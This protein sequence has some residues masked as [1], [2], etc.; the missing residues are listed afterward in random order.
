MNNS[1]GNKKNNKTLIALSIFIGVFVLFVFI[2]TKPSLEAKAIRQIEDCLNVPEVQAVFSIYKADLFKSEEFLQATRDKLNK[3]QLKQNDI[4]DIKKWLPAK[5]NNLNIIIVPDLSN[6]IIDDINNPDQ[7]KRDSVIISSIC[8]SFEEKVKLKMNSKDRLVVDVTDR[9]QAGG[10][11]GNLADSIMFDLSTFNNKSNRLYFDNK[12]ASFKVGISKLYDM[13]YNFEVKNPAGG[14]ADYVSYFASKLS[15]KL[16]KSTLDDD[17]QNIL[18][19]LTDG[20]LEATKPDGSII[21]YLKQ[22]PA[23]IT[24][25]SFT[26]YSDLE[27]YLLDVN[28]RK[29][30]S[31]LEEFELKK[32]W[33]EWLKT[34]DIKNTKYDNPVDNIITKRTDGLIDVTNKIKEILK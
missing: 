8:Y 5:T 34:M 2:L 3:F 18:I 17:Y 19:I 16:K 1:L 26:K 14:G 4:T 33:F 32:W 12:R 23:T 24:E 9:K 22:T 28:R 27:V 13:A 29:I 20:Y 21:A 6:R 11:L 31:D 25:T 30:A 7:I 15:N 10:Q